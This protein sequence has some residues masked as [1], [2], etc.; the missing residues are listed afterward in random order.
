MVGR[1]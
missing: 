1:E